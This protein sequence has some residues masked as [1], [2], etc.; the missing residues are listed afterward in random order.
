MGSMSLFEPS[1]LLSMLAPRLQIGLKI[2][3]ISAAGIQNSEAMIQ[4]PGVTVLFDENQ[5]GALYQSAYGVPASEYT[6]TVAN[7]IYRTH[8][9][10]E[11]DQLLL[12]SKSASIH[13]SSSKIFAWLIASV[14]CYF[15]SSLI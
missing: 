2:E 8:R 5:L 12:S 3:Q 15:H 13:L 6:D 11:A 14:T 7:F 9:D 10:E 1:A 4:N